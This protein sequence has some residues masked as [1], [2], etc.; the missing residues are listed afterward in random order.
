MKQRL[1]LFQ[2]LGRTKVYT[3]GMYKG[4][5]KRLNWEQIEARPRQEG[6]NVV[7]GTSKRVVVVKSPD[8]RVFEQAIFIVR[9]DFIA[10]RAGGG[11]DILR[12]AQ[13]VADHYIRSTVLEPRRFRLPVRLPLPAKI[14]VAA[15]GVAGVA[16]AALHFIFGIL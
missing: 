5:P 13:D 15:G 8:S 7:K 12:E 2:R 6:R 16:W 3:P 10:K 14:G 9:E 11:G 4:L 1:K